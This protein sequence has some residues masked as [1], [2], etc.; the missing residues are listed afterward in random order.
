MRDNIGLCGN[1]ARKQEL[2]QSNKTI[3]I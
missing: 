3:E 2:K 1:T